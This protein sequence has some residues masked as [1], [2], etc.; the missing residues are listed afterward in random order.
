[1]IYGD[2]N[3]LRSIAEIKKKKTNKYNCFI[4]FFTFQQTIQFLISEMAG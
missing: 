3:I 4:R 1:M 2:I